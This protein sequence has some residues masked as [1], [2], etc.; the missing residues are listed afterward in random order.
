MLQIKQIEAVRK[1]IPSKR[2]YRRNELLIERLQ[3]KNLTKNIMGVLSVVQHVVF[4]QAPGGFLLNIKNK[5]CG[6]INK[7]L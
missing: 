4:R 1:P 6:T 3:V 5:K 7:C 2:R